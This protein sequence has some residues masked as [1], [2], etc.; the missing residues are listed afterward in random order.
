[1]IEAEAGMGKS[2]MIDE[3]HRQADAM[4]VLTLAGTGDAVEQIT[5]YYAW[6]KVFLHILE[7]EGAHESDAQRD[8]VLNRLGPNPAIRDR[9]P[10]LNA[11]M[12]MEL[13][14][15]DVS[16]QMTAQVRAET[17]RALC[18][19]LLNSFIAGVPAALMV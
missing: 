3:L 8:W 10:V 5:P 12:P 6:R 9:A 7:Q 17:I 15:T 19:Q 14:E 2:R 4:R 13:P 18:I 11:V 16:L 1:M